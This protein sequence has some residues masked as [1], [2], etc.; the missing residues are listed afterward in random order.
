MELYI[1]IGIAEMK[2]AL[3]SIHSKSFANKHIEQIKEKHISA[4]FY[5]H[6]HA[7]STHLTIFS[8]H[9]IL[10]SFTVS[11]QNLIDNNTHLKNNF[12]LNKTYAKFCHQ[13]LPMH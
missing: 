6:Q 10:Q 11:K 9:H 3:Y 12:M 4:I 7:Q 13:Q 8:I 1:A 5:S 2:H